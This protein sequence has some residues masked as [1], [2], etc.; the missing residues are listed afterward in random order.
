LTDHP[1]DHD[2]PA[3]HLA[4]SG[5]GP[6]RDPGPGRASGSD[7]R[8]A[9]EFLD[10]GYVDEGHVDDGYAADVDDD[11]IE[12]PARRRGA[13]V[14][15]FVVL[16]IL[17][18]LIGGAVAAGLWVQRQI[19]PPGGPGEAITIEIPQGATTE[20]IGRLLA[21]ER[22]IADRTVWRW[23]IRINGGGPFQAGTYELQRDSAMG[24]VIATLEAGPARPEAQRFTVP[25]GLTF[26]QTLDRLADPDL[27]LGLDRDRLLALLTEGTVSSRYLPEDADSYE[28]ILYPET[29]EVPDDAD[30]EVVLR[31]MVG[32]LDSVLERLDVAAAEERL[33]LTPYEIL[34]VASLIE[35]ESRVP[36][37]RPKVARVVYNRLEQGIPLGIDATSCYEKGEIPCRLVTADF[38]SDSPYNTRRVPGLTPTPI[39]SPGADSIRAA[40]EPA[41]GP[42]IYYVLADTEGNHFFTDSAA[43]FERAKAECIRQGL[44]CG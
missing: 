10:E 6:G 4:R 39:S 40:L 29:Y 13:R 15:L 21:G 43:E 22:V 38:E 37:E 32:Q 27:G 1:D 30:E 11:Y 5:D 2:V 25:E 8:H 7:D 19:D 26:D 9:D 41:D 42:W 35:R 23:Y 34:I 44:G 12:V 3:R 24:S 36:D 16:G 17:V 20:D 18:V 33:G 14:A 28:G 31:R